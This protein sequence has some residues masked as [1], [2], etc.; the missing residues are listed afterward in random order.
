M[1]YFG[2]FAPHSSWRAAVVPTIPADDDAAPGASATRCGGR[3]RVIAFL[4]ESPVTRAILAHLGL[5]AAPAL[6]PAR[7]PPQGEFSGWKDED[8]L[9]PLRDLPRPVTLLP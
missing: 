1:R 2:R 4:V 5:P 3:R 8:L 6:A 7:A 9:C